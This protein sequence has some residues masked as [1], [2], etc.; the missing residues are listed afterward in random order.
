[1]EMV[2]GKK[3]AGTSSN[4]TVRVAIAL[5]LMTAAVWA[6]SFGFEVGNPIAAQDYRVNKS[7]AF[8]FR[9]TGCA[10]PEKADIS[11]TAEGIADGA[12][13]TVTVKV[14]QTARPGVYAVLPQ[15][16]AGRWAVV[17]KGS[18]GA[19]Q[20]GAV[21]PVGPRGFIREDSKF[22]ARPATAAEIDAAVKAM[23]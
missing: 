19:M 20:A 16:G 13:R 11:A 23:Q 5:A 14:T 4:G 17:L 22:F 7:A 9:I 15:W 12:R 2:I 21:I 18:C 3:I 6:Q 8:A 1:M 10:E